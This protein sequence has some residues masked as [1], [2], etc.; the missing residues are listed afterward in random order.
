MVG[1]GVGRRH[2]KN[3]G[4]R[5]TTESNIFHSRSVRDPDWSSVS[6]RIG[7]SAVV[8]LSRSIDMVTVGVSGWMELVS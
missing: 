6:I 8:D 7:I 3:S 4:P 2:W 1:I 5:K